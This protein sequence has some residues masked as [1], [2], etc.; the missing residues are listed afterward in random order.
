[1]RRTSTSGKKLDTGIGLAKWLAART[2]V[3][4]TPMINRREVRNSQWGGY[5]G[6]LGA[7]PLA[8]GGWGSARKFCIFLQK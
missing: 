1:M 6:D 8:A 5:F 4:M 3:E 2:V 7:K